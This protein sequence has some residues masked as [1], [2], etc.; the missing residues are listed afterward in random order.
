MIG[1]LGAAAE[2]LDHLL[3]RDFPLMLLRKGKHHLAF[4]RR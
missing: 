2:K 4:L 3:A 1:C